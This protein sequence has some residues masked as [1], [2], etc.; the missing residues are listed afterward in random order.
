LERVSGE[1]REERRKADFSGQAET[2]PA[3][4]A[5]RNARSRV[6]KSALETILTPAAREI[7]TVSRGFPRNIPRPE[8]GSLLIF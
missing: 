7:Y 1:S 4:Q 3:Q 2:R 6:V 8:P 5:L